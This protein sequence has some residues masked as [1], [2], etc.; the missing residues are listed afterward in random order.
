MENSKK[1]IKKD[2]FNYTFEVDEKTIG[3]LEM[4]YTNFN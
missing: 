4:V 2:D 1:W 3:T